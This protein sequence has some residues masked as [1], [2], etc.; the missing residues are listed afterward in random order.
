M[1]E[2]SWTSKKLI[3]NAIIKEF[4]NCLNESESAVFI[5]NIQALGLPPEL[6]NICSILQRLT[7]V[8][9]TVECIDCPSEV[10]EANTSLIIALTKIIE[11]EYFKEKIKEERRTTRNPLHGRLDEY[12]VAALYCQN[13]GNDFNDI[14]KPLVYILHFI[15]LQISKHNDWDEIKKLA[16]LTSAATS[17]RKIVACH[18]QFIRYVSIEKVKYNKLADILYRLIHDGDI[19]FQEQFLRAWSELYDNEPFVR[20]V[21]PRVKNDEGRYKEK[22]KKKVEKDVKEPANNGVQ[23]TNYVTTTRNGT[24]INGKR[25][26]G[27]PDGTC[28][29]APEVT[30]LVEVVIPGDIELD[31]RTKNAA[32]IYGSRLSL[33]EK[34]HLPW[35]PI[36]LAEHEIIEFVSFLKMK[37]N[38]EESEAIFLSLV[39]LTSKP[40]D[41]ISEINIYSE[42]PD[43]SKMEEDFIDLK[44]GTWNRKSIEMPDFF[45]P[46]LVQK[47]LL[48]EHSDWLSLPIPAELVNAIEKRQIQH[49]VKYGLN[50]KQVLN[51][52]E[53]CFSKNDKIST[54][55]AKFLKPFWKNNTKVHRRI[56]AAG[57]RATT[58]EKITHQFDGGYASLMLA[59][60]EFD[61]STTLYYLSAKTK[62]LRNDYTQVIPSLGFTVSDHTSHDDNTVVGS[63]LTIDKDKVSKVITKKRELLVNELSQKKLCI[64][65]LIERHNE[66]VNYTLLTLVAATGHRSR[67]EFGFTSTTYDEVN[68]LSLISDKIN[69]VDSAIRLIPQSETA[70]KQWLAY[71]NHCADLARTMKNYNDGIAAKLAKAA[72]LS[73]NDEPE[74]FHIINSA[75][76]TKL[77]AVSVGYKDIESYMAPEVNLPLNFLRHYFCSSMRGFGEYNFAKSLMGHVGNGEH[78]LSD[79]SLATLNDLTPVGTSIDLMLGEIGIEAIEYT[80]IKGP[81]FPLADQEIES[82]YKPP[83]LMRSENTERAEQIR[84]IR[85]LVSPKVRA[86]QNAKTHDKTVDTLLQI[87]VSDKKCGISLE[88]RIALLNRFTSKIIKSSRWFSTQDE[89]T[90]LC[91]DTNSLLDMRQSIQIKSEI[92]RWLLTPKNTMTP[93]EQLAR[94]WC[95][96]IVN[97]KMN[98]PTNIENLRVITSPSIYESGVAWFEMKD[99]KSDKLKIVHIDS[100]SL[101]LIQKYDISGLEVKSAKGVKSSI[102][103]RVLHKISKHSNFDA[104]ARKALENIDST[105]EYLRKSRSITTRALSHA[106]QNE[107]IQ[108][109]NLSSGTLCRWLSPVPISFTKSLIE[110]AEITL[111]STAPFSHEQSTTSSESYQ[112]SRQLLR[113]LQSNLYQ[114]K[115]QGVG[116]SN[117]TN[118]LIET[119]ANCVDSEGESNLDVLIES[120]KSLD[121][122]MVLLMLWLIDVSKRPGRG[123][124]K[125]TAVRTV[126]TYISNV[127]KPMIEQTIDCSFLNLSSEELGEIY[128]DALDSRSIKDRAQR[129]ENMR[130][131]HNFIMKTYHCSPVNWFDVEPTIGNNHHD[132]DANIISMREYNEALELLKNDGYSSSHER[133]INQLI[134]ILCYR[135]G[136]RSGEATHLRLNDIDI[137]NWVIHVRTSYFFRTK[138]INSNRRI[139]VSYFLSDEEKAL[140]SE[141]IKLIRTYHHDVE[142][143]WFFSDKTTAKCLVPVGEYISRVIEALRISTGDDSIRLH[144]ARHSFANYLL[145]LMSE[146]I[147]SQAMYK[148]V[149][150]WCRREDIHDLSDKV[151]TQLIGKQKSKMHILNAISLALGHVSPSTTLRS[152]IHVLNL[153]CAAENEK[154][155]I[156]TIDKAS[157]TSLVNIERSHIYKI[158]SRGNFERF[159]FLPLCS[160][161][162][163][164]WTGYQ[165]L[166]SSRKDLTNNTLTPISTNSEKTIYNQMN[167][168]ERIIRLAEAGKIVT[169]I[170]N[171][172]QLEFNFVLSVINATRQ[173]KHTTGYSGTN[174]SSD[175][176]DVVFQSNKKKQLKAAKYI[177]HEDFQVLL[178]KLAKLFESQQKE[179]SEFFDKYYHHRFGVVI[180]NTELSKFSCIFS[181][182][183]CALID[184]NERVTV[185]EQLSKRV[186]SV[187]KLIQKG[188]KQKINNDNKIIH[189]IFLLK[190]R[191]MAKQ[192]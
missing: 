191:E 118:V 30:D 144:H 64:E 57:I 7:D 168:V 102:Y 6:I 190:T 53:L 18:T 147:Y 84:W 86:L 93:Q 56:T 173:I 62:K 164:T 101:L 8:I 111:H 89:T 178:K 107:R 109:T 161:N 37:L 88:R 149:Q 175:L 127:A 179:F 185:R 66:Y 48:E 14:Q 39:L 115:Q 128:S 100:I 183:D 126:K 189:A 81:K 138:T 91:L 80:I 108:T 65:Q 46:T 9:T 17:L 44:A 92:N 171:A 184:T 4:L 137:N 177:K 131:F 174:I 114:L 90:L 22:P 140:I 106:Y 156:N 120:S 19:D 134:L 16:L 24:K 113:T 28:G 31:S 40:F 58:F 41:E 43:F 103:K 180:D 2:Q 12:P 160:Y 29:G 51:I 155:L 150:A 116:H 125:R 121:Q 165:Q 50:Q 38:T 152:Y 20:K 76:L 163:K 61:T 70:N 166:V 162:A 36:A 85:Q 23:D 5:K 13:F 25:I 146:N 78:I 157:L 105:G 11:S 45:S 151:K 158:L 132:A 192:Q 143:P 136:L 59:N 167:N 130:N 35:R 110:P 71:K 10:K 67:T 139:P 87:A 21:K 15:L 32:G 1:L 122:I 104:N 83:Y 54:V 148:E 159:G 75:G 63:W 176:S 68:S 27:A 142:N 69:F 47:E 187:V 186:G 112:K 141:Q 169:E 33:V 145:L 182:I 60:T 73:L 82:P 188:D 49:E 123:G 119:W 117:V 170:T 79:H 99:S 77:N 124:R 135:A 153:I 98:V 42:P 72:T 55:L 34:M 129:A 181:C 97:S 26:F 3:D 94:I 74:F 95:S 154:I 96:L 52:G 133:R 172:L